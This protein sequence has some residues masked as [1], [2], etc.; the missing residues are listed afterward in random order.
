[1]L[2]RL[3]TAFVG[4]LLLDS[5]PITLQAVGVLVLATAMSTNWRQ[6][7]R[8]VRTGQRTR[9]LPSGE[10]M[11]PGPFRVELVDAGAR[12]LEI[13]KAIREVT[14]AS[15]S[16]AKRLVNSVPSIVAKD[17]SGES[18]RLVLERVQRAGG[19]GT[20]GSLS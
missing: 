13:I 3:A 4:L 19:I 7:G 6:W 11:Q 20:V 17:L 14:P 16:E 10:F 2:P 12:P 18:A 8:Y 1:M 5:N 15:F 9:A